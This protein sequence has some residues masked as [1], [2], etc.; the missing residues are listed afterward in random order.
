[1][2]IDSVNEHDLVWRE[3][4][5]NIRVTQFTSSNADKSKIYVKKFDA[6][7]KDSQRNITIFLL[8]DVGQYHGRFI[9]FINW[10]RNRY[11]GI[12]FVAMDFVGHGLSSGTRGHIENFEN[13]VKDF[14]F[15]ISNSEKNADDNEK[16]MIL[17]HGL[18]GLV[19]LDLINR[20]QEI[21]EKKS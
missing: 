6:L 15:L 16:W 19:A 11:P 1:M 3:L 9:S 5:N 14:L 21:I 7:K 12:S 4:E 17:G 18:G 2:Q 10:T 13:I 20:Y 8:H